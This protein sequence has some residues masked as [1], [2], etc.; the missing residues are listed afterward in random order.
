MQFANTWYVKVPTC[1]HQQ[2]VHFDPGEGGGGE[3]NQGKAPHLLWRLEMRG[4]FPCFCA[5]PYKIVRKSSS[6]Q[7]WGGGGGETAAAQPSLLLHDI[8]GSVM[9]RVS[10]KHIPGKASPK[11]VDP[12]QCS[13]NNRV[14]IRNCHLTGFYRIKPFKKWS[15]LSWQ[16]MNSHKVILEEVTKFKSR[17]FLSTTGGKRHQ[18]LWIFYH[19]ILLT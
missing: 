7:S 6:A 8:R 13:T 19:Y 1:N 2:Q 9:G 14:K 12:W 18:I 4:N 16:W 15:Y 11:F 10:L 5:Q 17:D 3:I